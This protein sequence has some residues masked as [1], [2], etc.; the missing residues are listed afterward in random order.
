MADDS[1]HGGFRVLYSRPPMFTVVTAPTREALEQKIAD[2]GMM[3]RARED[4]PHG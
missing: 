2:L 1:K 3:F 4:V